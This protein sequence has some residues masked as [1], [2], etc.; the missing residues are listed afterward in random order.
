MP[1]MDYAQVADLYDSYVQ[2]ALDVDFFLA[3]AASCRSVLELTSGT[4]RLSLPLL[5]AGVPLTC[6][7][8]SPD[9]LA[10]LRRKLVEAGLSA[11]VHLQDATDFAL[12]E[13]F[14]LVIIPFNSFAEFLGR[15]AQQSA[16]AAIARHLVPGGRLIV[17]RHNPAVRLRQV[18]GELHVRGQFALPGGAGTLFLSSVERY[19]AAAEQVAGAQFYELYDGAGLLQ[20]KRFV[21]LRFDL[22][23]R[24]TMA[25]LA[26]EA[27]F[28][29]E[30]LYGDYQ[31]AT[32]EPAT[33]PFMIHVFRVSPAG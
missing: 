30:A 5:R 9:M 28:A 20:A 26:V 13:R 25:A 1:A 21:A 23:A 4:G 3:E 31:R 2:T 14:E 16:L 15:A 33:S 10:I 18:D 8:S 11:P 27:G 22:L 7:D 17:T 12:G 6:L 29:V 19:D 24:E 32:F